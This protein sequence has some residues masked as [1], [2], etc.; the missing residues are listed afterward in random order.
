MQ[1]VDDFILWGSFSQRSWYSY[2]ARVG[3]TFTGICNVFACGVSA[4]V[5][6]TVVNP[7]LLV[8]FSRL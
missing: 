1:G 4:D 6:P 8:K 5:R 2:N 3:P 7:L